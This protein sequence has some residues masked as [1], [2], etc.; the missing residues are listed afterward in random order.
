[1]CVRVCVRV[2]VYV[3]CVKERERETHTPGHGTGTCKLYGSPLTNVCCNFKRIPIE[4]GPNNNDNNSNNPY[5][6]VTPI[7]DNNIIYGTS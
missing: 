7:N 3:V 1:M 5:N 2:Y 4:Y 6:N